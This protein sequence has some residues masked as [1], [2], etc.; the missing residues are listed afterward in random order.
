MENYIP[1]QKYAALHRQSVHSVIKKT[2]NGELPCIEKEEN[3][4]K[5]I[6]VR[7]EENTPRPQQETKPV[8]DEEIDYKT[9]YEALHRDYL[10]LQ[11][12]YRKLVE[13]LEG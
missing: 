7:Y 11:T 13:M 3:G 12:K 2:M 9:A 10:I 5:V 6:Y 1:I 4:K 8:R